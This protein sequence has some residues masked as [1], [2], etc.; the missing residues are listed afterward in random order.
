MSQGLCPPSNNSPLC[1][2]GHQAIKPI[3]LPYIHPI[4]F[5][6]NEVIYFYARQRIVRFSVIPPK[7]STTSFYKILYGDSHLSLYRMNESLKIYQYRYNAS[8]HRSITA[9]VINTRT[10]DPC[11]L[12]WIYDN[13]SECG[14]KINVH[15]ALKP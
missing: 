13:N 11:M 7:T 10:T 9:S 2:T 12:R 4:Q 6:F 5:S 14:I 15:V 8:Y 3:Y 1:V